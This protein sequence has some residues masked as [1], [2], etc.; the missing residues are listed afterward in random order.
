MRPAAIA[1]GLI[2]TLALAG[3]SAGASELLANGGFEQGSL[4][5]SFLGGNLTELDAVSAPVHGGELAG[6]FAGSGQPTTQFV[7]QSM[8]VQ[9][10]QSY[11]LS[12]WAAASGDAINGAF[13]RISWF[14][15]GGA[16]VLH[17]DSLGLPVPDGSFHLLTTGQ[18]VSPAA[19]RLA[20]ASL[21]ILANSNTPFT[22][23]LDDFAFTGPAVVP[24]P[25]PTPTSTPVPA[26]T[27]TPVA[28]TATPGSTP[29]PAPSP[30]GAPAPQP[31]PP[32]TGAPTPVVEPEVFPRLVNGGFEDL[33][34]NGTP[35]GWHKQGGLMS[36]ATDRRTEGARAL[37]LSSNTTSTK[38]AYQTV[39]VEGGSYYEAS[40]QAD[41]GPGSEAAFLRL[42]WYA[43]A[44]GSG[45]A[46]SST[47]SSETAVAGFRPLTTGPVQA[48]PGA[49]SAKVRLMLRPSSAD[50]AFAYFDSAGFRQSQPSGEEIVRGP[51]GAISAAGQNSARPEATEAGVRGPTGATPVRLANVKPPQA[52][53]S[54]ARAAGGH[55]RDDWAILLAIGVAVAAVGLG[56]GY[57]LWQSR[58]RHPSPGDE[59]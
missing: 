13:L 38:W 7:Y 25:V 11:E 27:P 5:W 49:Q 3:S 10:N 12:G 31:T 53:T 46:I 54:E 8:N 50:P 44:D 1:F 14:D 43:T 41:A 52:D 19:A 29:K 51:G 55:G 37:V 18:R 17:D 2:A 58:Y 6:R 16:P 34:H 40:V 47:N 45:Q 22:V 42:S 21:Y 39:A 35:Y 28:P 33:R 57:E 26:V 48:P 36:T 30:T 4:G 32:G 15:S 23:H 56:G 9:P 24:P 20:R 59:P